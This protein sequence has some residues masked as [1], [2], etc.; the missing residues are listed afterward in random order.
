M[1]QY[2][3]TGATAIVIVPPRD[4]CG[5]ADHYRR[6]YMPDTMHHIEPH[7]TVVYPF[8]PYEQLAEIEPRLAQ[9]LA[10]CPP[11]R[12]SIRGFSAFRDSGV[13]YLRLA[14]PERVLSFYRA[15]HAEFPEYAAYGGEHDANLTP[16]L[17]VGRFSDLEALDKVHQELAV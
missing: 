12:L 16:H 11:T 5:Y 14:D 17:T 6:L 3:P 10:G 13:L 15:I 2:H 9:V 1:E 8:A 4:V 7:I